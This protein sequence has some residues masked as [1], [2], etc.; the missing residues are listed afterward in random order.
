MIAASFRKNRIRKRFPRMRYNQRQIDRIDQPD[1][2]CIQGNI[3]L[4]GKR[5][6]GLPVF[7][8]PAA[9]LP[10]FALIYNFVKGF[11]R[12][13]ICKLLTVFDG[14]RRRRIRA[15]GGVKGDRVCFRI[16]KCELPRPCDRI[17]TVFIGD[18]ERPDGIR[19]VYGERKV[20]RNLRS[21][22]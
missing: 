11:R 14:S 20:L 18:A 16:P 1:P 17:R 3:A 19:A 15:A 22:N 7:V 5:I 2:F 8:K 9:E 21:R 12:D 13:C 4:R 10:F 6:P